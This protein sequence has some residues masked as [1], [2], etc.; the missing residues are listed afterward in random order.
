MS[1]CGVGFSVERRDEKTMVGHGG[2]L[3]GYKTNTLINLDDK[4]GVVVLSNGDDTRPE[5]FARR[6]QATDQLLDL[7]VHQFTVSAEGLVSPTENRFHHKLRLRL[8]FASNSAPAGQSPEF[9]KRTIHYTLDGKE[10]TTNSPSYGPSR[11][12]FL[13][14]SMKVK[15]AL[16]RDGK[17]QGETWSGN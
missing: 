12:I 8:G 6:A 4:I 7:L 13:G 9:A 11:L 5:Q 10:P 2:S 15:A 16:F 1:G 14:N 3:A 17:K